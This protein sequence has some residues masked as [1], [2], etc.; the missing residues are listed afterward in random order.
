MTT[1]MTVGQ[2]L[3][4]GTQGQFGDPSDETLKPFAIRLLKEIGAVEMTA[5]QVLQ[6]S[7]LREALVSQLIAEQEAQV[8]QA[9]ADAKARAVVDAAEKVARTEAEAERVRQAFFAL[10]GISPEEQTRLVIVAWGKSFANGEIVEL[11]FERKHEGNDTCGAPDSIGCC[12]H[13]GMVLEWAILPNGEPPYGL[14]ETLKSVYDELYEL[15]GKKVKVF[16]HSSSKAGLEVKAIYRKEREAPTRKFVREFVTEYENQLPFIPEPKLN[17]EG[18]HLCAMGGKIPCCDGNQFAHRFP[19][20]R[21]VV[22]GWCRNFAGAAWTEFLR[23][24]NEKEN[25]GKG[26]RYNYRLKSGATMEA[27]QKA[28]DVYL[29]IH[30]KNVQ[31]EEI[32]RKYAVW[33]SAVPAPE[34][35]GDLD[36]YGNITV[37]KCAA[38][39]VGWGCCDGNQ[40][41]ERGAHFE[42]VVLGFCSRSSSAMFRVWKTMKKANHLRTADIAQAIEW[43]EQYCDRNNSGGGSKKSPLGN[44]TSLDSKAECER[45]RKRVIDRSI[46][47]YEVRPEPNEG[48]GDITRTFKK[49][50]KKRDKQ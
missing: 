8:V 9:E 47:D 41:A 33:D 16:L 20:W 43:A 24:Q 10:K 13:T 34:R 5:E 15:S 14:C 40:L 27:G 32:V 26:A 21:G 35:H 7:D 38:G 6:M 31:L 2:R 12:N 17:V 18:K 37:H 42:G 25:G 30:D 49:Y 4:I 50:K 45:R 28:A 39:K 44:K 36:G 1:N 11:P 3:H 22:Y 19:H 23:N 48:S 46:S 29:R